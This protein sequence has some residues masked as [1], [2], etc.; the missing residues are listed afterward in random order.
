MQAQPRSILLYLSPRVPSI[1]LVG[2]RAQILNP[3]G[4]SQQFLCR[5]IYGRFG[6]ASRRPPAA[7]GYAT[8]WAKERVPRS[9]RRQVSPSK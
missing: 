5:S 2:E 1:V 6:T 3:Q 8:E 7:I 4:S 9:A